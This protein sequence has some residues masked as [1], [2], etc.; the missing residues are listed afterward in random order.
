MNRMLARAT[1]GRVDARPLRIFLYGVEKI[2]KTT[3]AQG[4]KSPVFLEADR[5]TLH[6]DLNRIPI[7]RWEDVT[8]TIEELRMDPGH[9][10]ATVVFDNLDAIE[11]LLCRWV[12]DR[13][14]SQSLEEVGGGFGKGW[15]EV[16]EAWAGLTRQLDAL[17]AQRGMS[18]IGLAHATNQ[19]IHDPTGVDYRQWAPTLSKKGAAVWSAWAEN[20]LFATRVVN[21]KKGRIKSNSGA[22]I[23]Y[24]EWSPGVVAGNRR[25]LP[26]RLPLSWERFREA[27]MRNVRFDPAKAAGVVLPSEEDEPEEATQIP[28][29]APAAVPPTERMDRPGSEDP[30]PAE[31]DDPPESPGSERR[32][33]LIDVLEVHG[34]E[35]A[36]LRSMTTAALEAEHE[37]MQRQANL[38]DRMEGDGC[39]VGA[40]VPDV[41]PPADDVDADTP[42]EDAGG[43]EPLPG[44]D[45]GLTEAPSGDNAGSSPTSLMADQFL[46]RINVAADAL[47]SGDD[48]EKVAAMLRMTFQSLDVLGRM[49]R[50]LELAA[51]A[52]AGL[53]SRVVVYAVQAWNSVEK[54]DGLIGWVEKRM[55]EPASA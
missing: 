23:L 39:E 32:G 45:A 43:H 21:A 9:P 27:I 24:T 36:S 14:G 53:Q 16:A 50:V 3:F 40:G 34:H 7:E 2:G 52:D 4:A 35:R 38:I 29:D 47:V 6:L 31:P 18:V 54:L 26:P 33:H 49:A 1:H 30:V 42:T 28:E 48:R 55:K 51:A 15:T 13:H 25:N 22:R 46:S 12:C 8:Q 5:G 19:T 11:S 37:S 44:A 41:D 10:Y 20:I 17:Q